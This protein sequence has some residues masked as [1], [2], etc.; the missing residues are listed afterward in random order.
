MKSS[1]S[2][3]RLL[4]MIGIALPRTS[5]ASGKNLSLQKG[6]SNPAAN[7]RSVFLGNTTIELDNAN[8]KECP[9][10][11]QLKDGILVDY[12][13]GLRA[14]SEAP[15]HW[16]GQGFKLKSSNKKMATWI[17]RLDESFKD[18]RA[19]TR[20]I[21]WNNT[22]IERQKSHIILDFEDSRA[23]LTVNIEKLNNQFQLANAHVT[24][25]GQPVWCWTV[26]KK[27]SP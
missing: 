16:L 12:D 21:L 24:V 26:K 23:T 1:Y 4:L 27:Q 15:I 2:R 5:N 22:T 25:N 14:C 9:V 18:C 20:N 13:E 3:L 10:L 17:A 8:G 7:I 19:R 11:I 6:T